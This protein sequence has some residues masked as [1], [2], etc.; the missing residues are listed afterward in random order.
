MNKNHAIFHISF[1]II[2]RKEDK[3]LFLRMANERFLNVLDLPGGR[4]EEG[5]EEAPFLEILEREVKEEIG[6]DVKYKLGKLAFQH[7]R[8]IK[9]PYTLIN[10]YEGEYLSGDVKLSSEHLSY[11]WINPQTYKFKKEEFFS[12]EEYLAFKKYFKF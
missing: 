8:R 10:I 7:Y 9:K 12:E 11:E 2:L 1:K 3:V 4:A 5:G 6:E